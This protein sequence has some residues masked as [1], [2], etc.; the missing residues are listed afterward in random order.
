MPHIRLNPRSTLLNQRVYNTAQPTRS[1]CPGVGHSMGGLQ[2]HDL[3]QELKLLQVRDGP[4][5]SG[6]GQDVRE[7]EQ[8][9]NN[10]QRADHGAPKHVV[11]KETEHG[12][13][14][15]VS[16]LAEEED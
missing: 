7:G 6:R 12:R 15:Q 3:A 10:T 8:F 16:K 11:E 2:V 9:L 13:P 4:R 5:D 14:P 1:V